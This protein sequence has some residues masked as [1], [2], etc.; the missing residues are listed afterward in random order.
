MKHAQCKQRLDLDLQTLKGIS[1]Q[2]FDVLVA[3]VVGTMDR[4]LQNALDKIKLEGERLVQQ[5]RQISVV[6]PKR[7]HKVEQTLSEHDDRRRERYAESE[8]QNTRSGHGHEDSR[9]LKRRRLSPV[10]RSSSPEQHQDPRLELHPG[11]PSSLDDI[12]N[13]MKLKIEQQTYSLESLTK[14]NHEVTISSLRHL[15]PKYLL[16]PVL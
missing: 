5:S 15:S 13:Q 9:D 6:P 7:K 16:T 1:E 12:L 11:M 8:K 4:G 14:E 2:I 10:N 3:E